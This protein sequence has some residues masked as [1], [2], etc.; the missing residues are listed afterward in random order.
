MFS[1]YKSKHLTLIKG[2]RKVPQKLFHTHSFLDGHSGIEDLDFV[3]F[4]Q[5]ETHPQL[6]EGE[7]LWQDRL[8]PF[9]LRSK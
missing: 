3:I 7:T 6:K 4:V 9:T 1:N 5:C 2:K 8:K